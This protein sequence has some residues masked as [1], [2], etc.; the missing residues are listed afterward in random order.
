LSVLALALRADGLAPPN[1]V[2]F[3]RS[4][5]ALFVLALCAAGTGRSINA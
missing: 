1:L 3:R 2:W 5:L 4:A